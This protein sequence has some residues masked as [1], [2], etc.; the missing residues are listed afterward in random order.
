MSSSLKKIVTGVVIFVAVVLIAYPK[1]KPLFS[2]GE[3][4]A[5][6]QN[7]GAPLSVD[8]V[9]VEPT[10]V[11][12]KIFSTGSILANEEVE[13]RSEV[14]GK[15]TDIYLD[16]G[17]MV[18]K[19]QLLIK[20]NDSELQAQLQRAQYRLNLASERER[21]QQQLLEKGGIS[22]EDYDA[23]LN[24]VNVLKSEVQL[25]RAQIDKTEIRAPFRGRVGLKYVSDGSYISPTTRIASLQNI[26]PV[27][28]DF[29]VPERYVN[30][31]RV[32]DD[33]SFTVQGTEG[34]FDGEIYAI[35]PKIDSQ[36]RTLQL[37][38]LSDNDEGLLVP[39]AFAD[40]ELI[41]ETIDDAL[42]IPTISLIPELQGQKVYLFKNGSV[43]EQRV[44]TGLRTAERVR[45]VDGIQPGDTVLTTG[46]LQVRQGMPVRINEIQSQ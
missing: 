8:A 15:I 36:T 20:I 16:E 28:L 4:T 14:S 29:S 12:D 6:Q 39:G 33:I 35:E 37:R 44:E 9:M 13:L 2:E 19:N 21:R 3:E 42:M 11:Q 41:L 7:S 1:V 25:I 27:K 5:S 40:I 43:A 46:L 18:D 38:A 30:R 34:A 22:Q 32:G 17:K 26:N 45:I 10:R 24:E 23:T 31:V